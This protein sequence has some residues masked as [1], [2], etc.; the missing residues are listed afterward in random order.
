MARL[1]TPLTWKSR[2]FAVFEPFW[3]IDRLYAVAVFGLVAGPFA[4]YK[5]PHANGFT[6]VHLPSRRRSSIWRCRTAARTQP[7]SLPP[8]T[9]TGGPASRRRSLSHTS[10]GAKHLCAA[11]G[12]T[13][14]C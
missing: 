4:I 8:W 5:S 2:H 10:R 14:G 1:P 3:M 7:R 12:A 9:S 11:E 13:L 6:L